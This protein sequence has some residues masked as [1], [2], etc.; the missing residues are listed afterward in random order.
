M[1]NKLSIKIGLLFFVFLLIIESFLFVLLYTSLA[2][3][4]INEVMDSLLARGNTHRNVLEEKYDESTLE[5]VRMMESASSFSVIITDAS[6]EVVVQ[7]NEIH[8][9]MR[10]LI[11]RS[12][13][14]KLP[15]SGSVIEDHWEN[16]PYIATASPIT[17]NGDNKG[18]VFMFVDTDYVKRILNQLNKQF[19]FAGLVTI[20]MT[21]ITIIV[22]S[23]LITSPLIKMKEAT[24][25]L[26]KGKH[27][28]A[29][30]TGRKDELG[31]LA[32]AITT[33]SEDLDR[34]KRER[35]EFLA[36]ISHELRTPITYIKGYADIISRQNMTEAEVKTYTAI[37][38]EESEHLSDLIKNLFDLAKMD[39][40][41]F[42][43]EREDTLLCELIYTVA[44]RMEP[45]FEEDGIFLNVHCAEESMHIFVDPERLQQVLINILDNAK[46][47]SDKGSEV[48]L[49]ATAKK[50][51]VVITIIDSGEGIPA[52]ELPHVFDRLYR[53]EKSRS[54][55]S[56]GSGLGLTIAKEIVESHGGHIAIDSEH[57]KGTRVTITLERGDD[58]A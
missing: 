28:V 23:R 11:A 9:E 41:R 40:N 10:E 47:H 45:L 35:K 53:V 26:S 36:S 19:V 58:I 18:N 34:L 31:E 30:T 50:E 12:N 38:R 16:N 7:S 8:E 43:I 17:S 33:L 44:E 22:L 57:G 55:Q 51:A 5:H 49:E 21:I 52:K 39:Q 37:I 54:R 27:K 42:V 20:T 32:K 4:R 14:E 6:G 2:N 48:S 1:L 29:L 13:Q 25:H 3:E 56:G 24:E 46:K 15:A